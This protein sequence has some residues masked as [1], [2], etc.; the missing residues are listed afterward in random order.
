MS[1][2][3]ISVSYYLLLAYRNALILTHTFFFVSSKFVKIINSNNLFVDYFVFSLHTSSSAN[4]NSL[5]SFL[6]ILISF[7]YFSVLL[8]WLGYPV[9]QNRS[10][11]GHPGLGAD[12]KV[13]ASRRVTIRYDV[14]CRLCIFSNHSSEL[15]FYS[16]FPKRIFLIVSGG[17]SILQNFCS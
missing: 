8:C 7:I 11:S 13:K 3:L 17:L 16:Q 2:F 10:D 9:Q 5:V 1:V 15:S 4:N 12:L 14:F 6:M